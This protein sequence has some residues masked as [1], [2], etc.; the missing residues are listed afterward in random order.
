MSNYAE[1]IKYY[2]QALKLVVKLMIL[3][4]NVSV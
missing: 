3:V 4:V 2:Q 1:A